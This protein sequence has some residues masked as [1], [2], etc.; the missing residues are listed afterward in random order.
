MP[1]LSEEDGSCSN[2]ASIEPNQL[3]SLAVLPPTVTAC[4]GSMAPVPLEVHTEDWNTIAVL[5]LGD[6]KGGCDAAQQMCVPRAPPGFL[7]CLRSTTQGRTDIECPSEYP[8]GYVY[9]DKIDFAASCS[10][11]ECSPPIG[12]SC[13]A[14]VTAYTSDSCTSDSAFLEATVDDST[15]PPPCYPVQPNIGLKGVTAAWVID[16]PGTCDPI[17]SHLNGTVAAM[18]ST[19]WEFCC[20]DPD[21]PDP[22]H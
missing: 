17:P 1:F 11:C 19:A 5:C 6:G 9:Y 3:Q 8:N 10:P 16:Y 14:T 12:S 22:E 7:Q 21:T 20:A 15:T 2:D 13:T 18:E 4:V